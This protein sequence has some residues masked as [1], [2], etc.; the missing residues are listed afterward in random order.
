MLRQFAAGSLVLVAAMVLVTAQADESAEQKSEEK[1][2]SCKCP[3]SGA[4]AKKDQS[5]RFKDGT[6][7]FCCGKCKG[8]FAKASPADKAKWHPKANAQLVATGQYYQNKCPLTGG[9]LKTE[10]KVAGVTVKFCCGNCKK[11]V[12][13]AEDDQKLTL[14]FHDA[15]FKKGFDR[16]NKKDIKEE[17]SK[18]ES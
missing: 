4:D 12:D 16:K 11:K 10:S 14:V 1:E 6:V 17:A 8:A 15:P 5:S 3:I 13:G 7:Y 18:E 9:P 2:F